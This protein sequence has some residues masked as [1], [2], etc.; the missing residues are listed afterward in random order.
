[1]KSL[2]RLGAAVFLT[3][4][5]ALSALAGEPSPPCVAPQPGQI[6]TPPC[7]AAPRDMETPTG[8]STASGDVT[9]A[10]TETS[11]S[12]ITARVLVTFLPLF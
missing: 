8:A 12:E 6:D 3:S 9:L 11:F 4:A 10:S 1:M 7:A 5:L 2:K